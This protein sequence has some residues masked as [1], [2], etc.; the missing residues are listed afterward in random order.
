MRYEPSKQIASAHQQNIETPNNYST[1]EHR[2]TVV[3]SGRTEKGSSAQDAGRWPQPNSALKIPSLAKGSPLSGIEFLSSDMKI[4]LS[5]ASGLFEKILTLK[6]QNYGYP[7]QQV[8][9]YGRPI[10]VAYNYNNVPYMGPPQGGSP[11]YNQQFGPPSYGHQPSHSMSRTPSQP[12]RPSSANQNQPAVVSS[13][14]QPQHAQPKPPSNNFVR[15]KRSAAIQIKNAAGETVD[16]S[17]LKPPTSPALSSQ[18]KTPPVAASTPPPAPPSASAPAHVRSDSQAVPKSAK[19]IQ[20][21]LKEKIKQATQ[22]SIAD[23]VEEQPKAIEKAPEV[24]ESVPAVDKPTDDAKPEVKETKASEEPKPSPEQASQETKVEETED[25]KMER[26]IQEMEEAEA[27]READEAAHQK[28][29]AAE[30]AAAKEKEAANQPANAAE[31]DKKMREAEREMERLEEEKERKRQQSEAGGKTVSVADALAGVENGTEPKDADSPKVDSVTDKLAG[32]KLGEKTSDVSS[33]KPTTA[34]KRGAKQLNLAPLTT[35]PVEPPQPSAA[36]QSLKSA[37]FLQIMEQDLYPPGINSPNPALNAAVAKKGKTF[38]Y[39]ATFLLQFQK[40]FTE[41]PSV[42]FHQQVKSLIGDGD[43]GRSASSRTQAPGSARQ[44]SRG[45]GGGFPTT[46]GNFGATPAGRTIPPGTTSAERFAQASG[47]MSRPQPNP[48]ASFQRPGGAFPSSASM[49]RTSSQSNMA[50]LQN[51]NRQS[52]RSTRGSRRGGFDAKEA[53]AAKTMPL[54][55]GMDLKPI[56]TTSTGWKPTSVGNKAAPSI[57]NVAYLEPEMVQR[58]VKAALNKMTPEK[59]EKISEQILVIASQSKDE[60]DGRTL[61]QVI[62]LTFEKAT[63]EAHWASMYAKFCRRMLETMSA[64]VRDEGIKD[65]NGNVVSGGN[66]F[67]KYL[68]NRCQEEFERGWTTNLPEPE[69]GTE[70]ETAAKP[71]F[72]EAVMLSEEYYLAE[73]AKRRGLGLVQF[74]GELYKLNMLTERIMHECVHKLV[75]YKGVPDE[76]E[77]ESLSK[78]LRTIGANLDA[79]E[80]GKPMMDAYF[81]RIQNMIEIPDL[82]SRMQFMLLDVI[83]LRKANWMSKENNKGPK[84]LDEVRVEVSKH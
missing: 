13:T 25:E 18:T 2:S 7:P 76:A 43:G 80:K 75:D 30:K 37:R 56:L 59:F 14:P 28:K 5:P 41:Q 16:F 50:N 11:G 78:L 24:K 42:E 55:A 77:I 63:D 9:N 47:S 15:P 45:G 64:E 83:D 32:M 54:T 29:R 72:G 44:N 1:D 38:K 62:Q 22:A 58:K 66:L 74:I 39:D 49:S 17:G 69:N 4:D 12:E 52:S 6:N 48:M 51:S 46:M 79:T 68:L 19:E 20:N 33:Q 65:K 82:Q 35:K 23:K 70:G 57:S 8:D 40:V 21:E 81:Q 67:R 26:M 84:T 31:A 10:Q 34:E 53:Q 3:Y 73:A 71:A 27:K 60:S 61:R 36:L